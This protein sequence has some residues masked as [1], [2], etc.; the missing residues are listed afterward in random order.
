MVN[1]VAVFFKTR[2]K[3]LSLIL[4]LIVLGLFALG[5]SS[6]PGYQEWSGVASQNGTLYFGTMD[7]RVFAI[8]PSARSQGAAFPGEGEW[9]F[10]KFPAVGTPGAICGPACAP[11]GPRL[12]VYT[13]PV[14]VGDLVC[15]GT[16]T[17]GGGKL[18]AINRLAPGYTDNAPLRSKGEWIYPSDVKS[19]GA[20]VGSPVAVNNN[21]YVGSSDGKLYALDVVYGEKN[22][23][24][25]TKGKIW[26]SPDVGDGVVYISNYA[27]Q[28]YAVKDGKELWRK[29]YSSVIA[30]SPVVSGGTIFFGTFD[31]YL[32][33]VNSTDGAVRWKF[34]A[35]N[36]FWA[37]PVIQN[38]VV[39]AGCLDH[40]VY[41]LNV[42]TGEEVWQFT[43]DD[44]IVATP[45]LADGLLVVASNSGTVYMLQTDSGKPKYDAVSVGGPVIAPLHSEGSMIYVHSSNR[46]VY[47]LDA[48]S[49]KK[50]WEFSYSNIK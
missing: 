4:S 18:V 49:G 37:S 28:L 1:A 23:E 19:I 16:Y 24:F 44:Q 46:S 33:A 48:Q 12:S 45:V 25:D 35:G 17:G 5:C 30:S 22:W 6:G 42:N 15:V 7:G 29:D 36:W 31:H 40:K 9:V 32:Y 13:T 20:I 43:A 10:T 34:G 26:T 3:K 14:V 21:L 8:N 50:L 41:A 47:C 2:T 38:E 11:A 39:F 27:K